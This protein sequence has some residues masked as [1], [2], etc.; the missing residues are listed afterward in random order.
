MA[1]FERPF[2]TVGALALAVVAAVGATPIALAAPST[3]TST[4]RTVLTTPDQTGSILEED[5]TDM[6]GDRNGQPSIAVNPRNP[7]DLVFTATIFAPNRALLPVGGCFLAYSTN[8]GA[9]WTQVPWP[10]GDRP[11]CGEPNVAVDSHGTFYILNNQVTGAVPADFTNKVVVSRS[12][13]GGRTWSGPYT[14]PL[15]LSGAPKLRVDAATGQIYALGGLQWENPSGVSVSSDGGRTWSAPSLVPG[16]MPCIGL[17]PGYPDVCG[18]PGRQIAVYDGILASVTQTTGGAVT[19]EVSRDGGQSWTSRLVTDGNGVYVPAGTGSLVPTPQEGAAA[20]PVPWISA[21][22][23]HVGRFAV[24]VP[25]G[26]NLE[27]YLTGDAGRSW[28]GPTVISAPGA[29]RPWMDFGSNGDLGVMWRTAAVNVYS[30]VS[31]DHGHSFS[32]PVQVNHTT[33]PDGQSGPPGDRFS[34]IT[35]AGGYAYVTW[36]DARNGGADGNIDGILA[37]VPLSL[38]RKAGTAS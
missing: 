38:Y 7:D 4:A 23:T 31:F 13:D 34:W 35:I 14:T 30:V 2:V 22:P 15:L 6:P 29:E 26:D 1:L 16:P 36:D 8:A 10:L 20:D 3:Q 33:E 28:T 25:R 5:V 11:L 9:S 21:D 17:V 32:A 24:M 18:Y 37:R 27:V 19:F 12:T